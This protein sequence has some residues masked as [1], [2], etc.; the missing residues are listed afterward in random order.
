MKI[1][2]KRWGMVNFKKPR[3]SQSECNISELSSY[4]TLKY[5][6][7]LSPGD[8][9]VQIVDNTCPDKTLGLPSQQKS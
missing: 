3:V 4:T 1:N 9:T 8:M 6:L 2:K 7:R 5:F